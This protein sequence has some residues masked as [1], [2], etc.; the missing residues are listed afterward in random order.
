MWFTK[1]L[2]MVVPSFLNVHGWSMW[3]A[4][5]NTFGPQ[6]TILKVL[7][8]PSQGLNVLQSANHKDHPFI[9]GKRLGLN[10]LQRANNRDHQ[11]TFRKLETKSKILVNQRDHPCT[12][13]D[14]VS[15]WVDQLYLLLCQIGCQRRPRLRQW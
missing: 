3:F 4:L 14:K 13:L 12:L 8:C 11:Y 15:K 7:A 6:P 5:C 10:A 2:D 1:I 9:F